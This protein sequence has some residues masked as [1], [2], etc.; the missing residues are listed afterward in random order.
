MKT[1]FLFGKVTDFP[2]FTDRVKE[3]ERLSKNLLNGVNSIIVSPR[4]WGKTSLVTHVLSDIVEKRKDVRVCHIDVFNCRTEEQFYQIYANAILSAVETKLDKFVEAARRYLGRLVPSIS[5][6]DSAQQYELTF[7]VDFKDDKL[8]VGDVLNLPQRISEDLNIDF[9]VAID[10]FQSIDFYDDSL[11][12]Q[13]KL[14]SYWQHHKRVTYCLYGSKRHM[15]LD[16][17]SNPNMPFFKFGDIMFLDKISRED[18][19]EFIVRRFADTGKVIDIELSGIIADKVK[20][21]PYYVQQLSQQVWLRTA[22]KCTLAIVDEAFESMVR[23]L[24]LLFTN[25]IDSLTSRQISFL[26]AVAKGEERFSSQ[27]V[28]SKYKLGTSANIKNLRTSLLDKDLIDIRVE[29]K[30]EIQD[31]V[32]EWWLLNEYL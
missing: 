28:L 22:R 2:N 5:L 14:R 29:S 15:L 9:I 30:I 27:E 32:F 25:L 20:N 17:F 21:H 11:A 3:S 12:F 24:S 10:E 31:P 23:Q 16:I 26:V 8:S 6:S 4:R 13:R 18:W 1:P 7:G 19:Q